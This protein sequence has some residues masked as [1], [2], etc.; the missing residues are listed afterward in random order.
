MKNARLPFILVALLVPLALSSAADA[1][2]ASPSTTPGRN[3]V[4]LNDGRIFADLALVVQR[5]EG[6]PAKSAVCFSSRFKH[7]AS[8][9]D[10]RDTF[11][12]AAAFHATGL[13][14]VYSG[15]KEWIGAV[16]QR[17]YSFQ[18]T[19]HPPLFDT[20]GGDTREKG[21]I[22][23]RKGE[24]VALSWQVKQKMYLGCANNPEFAEIFFAHAAHYID[25]G[26][27]T[28]HMDDQNMN[29]SA[30]REGGCFCRFCQE[31]AAREG[32][33]PNSPEFQKRSTLEF[34]R[35]MLPRIDAHAGRHV[36][37]SCN[38]YGGRLD[39]VAR[40]FDFGIAELPESKLSIEGI[41]TIL[42]T[43][44]QQGKGQFFTLVS[45]NVPRN[46]LGIAAAYAAGGHVIV[47]WDVYMGPD[48]P[49]YFGT[50]EEYA[51]LYGFVRA[52][53]RLF[54]GYELA[55]L[56]LDG[57]P[58]PGYEHAPFWVSG[59]DHV[60]I[61]AR[62]LPGRRDAPV[63]LQCVDAGRQAAPFQLAFDARRFFGGR[64]VTVDL[65]IPRIYEA[66]LHA[67]AEKTKNYSALSVRTRLA[68]GRVTSVALPALSP[69]GIVVVAPQSPAPTGVWPPYLVPKVSSVALDTVEVAAASASPD[70]VMCYT[71]DGSE[72][73][74]ASKVYAAPIS[75]DHTAV[76]KVR[77]FAGGAASTV[78]TAT[79]TRRGAAVSRQ[80]TDLPGLSL[81][82][83]A[84][85]LAKSDPDGAAVM[86]WS[87]RAG[88]PMLSQAKALPD[89]RTATPPLLVHH[90]INGH[91]TVRFQRA[92]DLLFIEGFAD[93]H[94]RGAF[95][96]FLVLRSPDENFGATGTA[97]NGGGAV[98][99]LSFMR[100]A[101]TYNHRYGSTLPVNSTAD[102]T[103]V[104][105]YQHN[106]KDTVTTYANGRLCGTAT[107]ANFAPP[108]AFGAGGSLAMPFWYANK[109]STGEVAEIIAFDR[110]LG[111]AERT[112]VEHHLD[113]RYRPTAA[114]WKV[115]LQ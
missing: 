72:P 46:R 71:L 96:L 94:L 65:L 77:A 104:A 57:L 19:L 98:P 25:A 63:V 81:W 23:D 97:A 24:R 31:K 49:R 87:A 106:G 64:P 54:D 66:A 58:D 18:G 84:E 5:P 17:G 41:N 1:P 7:P 10:P 53:A 13:N 109:P 55:A 78:T 3:P 11:A 15:D 52:N 43:V 48:E 68:E 47:P 73:S 108:P 36:P 2:Q 70:A 12:A 100:T 4:A 83:T 110:E 45:R 75:L 26:A 56:S 86:R 67:Q 91:P 20:V 113:L 74:A 88:P 34:Y 37:F 35:R 89:R 21:R 99:R 90:G 33:A 38:N 69:W 102:E 60:S 103:A 39:E 111:D 42:R 50:A 16:K 28:L 14:W 114:A 101:F 27:E 115:T 95:T 40:L 6:L 22:Q 51:D 61:V 105:V 85:D 80:P 112:A 30:V 9:S 32:M 76:V 62:A 44:E 59:N 79:F 107:G 29:L 93:A 8:A 92:T 82:L